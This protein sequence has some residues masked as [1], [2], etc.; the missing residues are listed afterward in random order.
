[1]SD[2]WVLDTDAVVDVLRRRH[3]VRERLAQVSP[4]DV[5]VTSMSVA[6]LVY[7]AA[8]ASDP[9]R[10]RAELERFLAEIRVLPFG[11]RAARLHGTL[12]HALRRQPIGPADLV[13]AATTLAAG[14][15]LVTANVREFGRVPGL[16]VEDWRS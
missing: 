3:G 7:G 8:N 12:R 14:A 1:M 5:A 6:E 16:P 10:T 13:I 9:D 11:P 15:T 2:R 4:A